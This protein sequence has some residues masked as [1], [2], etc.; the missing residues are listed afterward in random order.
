PGKAAAAAF[1]VAGPVLVAPAAGSSRSASAVVVRVPV[2]DGSAPAGAG[3]RGAAPPVLGG[4]VPAEARTALPADSVQAAVAAA[5]RVPAVLGSTPD[6]VGRIHVLVRIAGDLVQPD[7]LSC[8]APAGAP[9]NHAP[10]AASAVAG[11]HSAEVPAD[12]G[13]I[14]SAVDD[15]PLSRF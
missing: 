11:L 14:P 15:V 2:V 6:G 13:S 9:E 1:A 8:S 5:L 7:A 10:V 3:Q 4:S 12:I